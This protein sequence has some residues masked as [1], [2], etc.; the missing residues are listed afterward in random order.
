MSPLINLYPSTC[1][2]GVVGRTLQGVWAKLL[3]VSAREGVANIGAELDDSPFSLA[4]TVI[5]HL[6]MASMS[7]ER[8]F[9][10]W[11]N[12]LE[13]EV[14]RYSILSH[15]LFLIPSKLYTILHHSTHHST[16]HR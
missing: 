6:H 5:S 16:H 15:S 4:T 11:Q 7:S 8:A 13:I 14:H 1:Y 9:E 12:Q 3:E 10:R 2:I